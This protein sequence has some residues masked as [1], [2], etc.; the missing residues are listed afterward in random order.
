MRH[1]Y[2]K[3]AVAFILT[4]LFW[5]LYLFSPS[6]FFSL[7]DRLR[8]Y[9]FLLRGELPRSHSITIVDIDDASLKKHGQWPWSRDKIAMLLR[10]ISE[11]NPGVIGLDMVFPEPDRSSP[12]LLA[13]RYP[14][15][16]HPL[17][18]TDQILAE[19]FK[20]S[21]VIGGYIFTF[22]A[23]GG[24]EAPS[25]P[26]V[27]IERG[28]RN[29]HTMLMPKGLLVN[30]PILQD[31]LYSSGFFNNTPD[32]N[33]MIRSV[34]LVMKYDHAVYDSLALEMLRVYSGSAKVEIA[35]DTVGIQE[36]T[37][38]P[39]HIPVDA[40]GRLLVNFR[41]GG[42]HF[43]Y[44]SAHDIL[45]GN[46][47]KE[48]I[49]GRFVLVGTSAL[50]LYDA[51][52]IAYDNN[53]PGVEIHAN[54][55]D[56]ILSGD[57]LDAKSTH[58]AMDLLSI[59]TILGGMMLL[60]GLASSSFV[61]PLAAISLFVL[62]YL[63]YTLLF[64]YGVVLNL[65]F[66]LLSFFTALV[67]SITMDYMTEHKKKEQVKR[68]LGKKVSP[69][70]MEYLLAHTAEDIVVAKELEATIFFSDIQGFSALAEQFKSPGKLIGMLNTYMTPMVENIMSH[71]GTVDKFIGDAIM[72][73]WNAPLEIEYHADKALQSAISQLRIL[74]NMNTDLESQYGVR[75][76]IGIGLHTDIV[77]VGDMG[78]AGRSDYTVVGD[79]VNL[80]SRIEG[81]T[82]YY[83]VP[84]LITSATREALNEVYQI[85]TI[86]IVTV[87]GKKESVELYEVKHDTPYGV[88]ELA[89]YQDA[90]QL[91]RSENIQEAKMHFDTLMASYPSKL[92]EIYVARCDQYL[93]DSGKYFSVVHAFDTKY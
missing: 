4:V 85:R 30:E 50:G 82:R 62:I 13:K 19:C 79:G 45:E 78:S 55:I 72:A 52:A 80:A 28:M 7:D 46:V 23:R 32:E 47:S 10:H 11:K 2:Y 44:V 20:H 66:P 48:K 67:A 53:I 22:D 35:G 93:A 83:D 5:L 36:I 15:I 64:G 3:V 17:P 76:R 38:G 21:P 58:K 8:D 59:A 42:H 43:D 90:I 88:E 49:E 56:N 57:F 71:Q 33:G 51:R 89:L 84:L 31:S 92:Y 61:I 86:D 81:L 60:F 9:M 41:G 65:L 25:I 39:Y 6:S 68:M 37:F 1:L 24:E 14:E 34:P 40:A 74:K 12:H 26:A 27:F 29:T 63:Y 77:T 73:Y 75:L 16:V 70:V 69:S 54:V 18:N 91:Y 87:K